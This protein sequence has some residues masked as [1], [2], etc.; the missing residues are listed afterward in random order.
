MK[1][2]MTRHHKKP[3][4]IGG[5]DSPEN[6]SMLPKNLHSAW[7]CLFKTY[8]AHRIASLINK[9]YLDPAFEFIVVPKKTNNEKL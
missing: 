7:H 9:Y 6:I 1:S 4:S 5:S 8:D 2:N 3:K